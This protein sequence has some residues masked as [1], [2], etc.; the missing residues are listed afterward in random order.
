M[1][2]LIVICLIIFIVGYY[3]SKRAIFSPAV[4]SSLLW[5]GT[6]LLYLLLYRE[7]A[8][9]TLGH[10]FVMG[11]A[12]WIISFAVGSLLLQT[13]KL[14]PIYS[15]ECSGSVMN[16]FFALSLC[17][18]PLLI[19]HLMSALSSGLT[20]SWAYNLRLSAL[21]MNE[22]GEVY[23]PIYYYL[24]VATY[25]L[26]LMKADKKTWYQPVIMGLLLLLF[27]VVMM[28]KLNILIFFVI[29]LFLLHY[30]GILK[31]GQIV[32][33]GALMV[34]VMILLFAIRQDSDTSVLETI[35]DMVDIYALRSCAA[36]E[37]LLPASSAHWGE[38]VFRI[39]YAIKYKLGF[40]PIEP[41]ETMLPWISEPA[42]TNTYTC[43]YPFY[44][45]FGF[46]GIAIFGFLEG[47]VLGWL[48]RMHQKGSQYCTALYAYLFYC[49]VMQFDSE[50]MVTILSAHIKFAIMIW[51]PF[52]VSRYHLLDIRPLSRLK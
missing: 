35:I 46:A 44:K 40:S 9:P 26:S 34:G 11:A 31:I 10:K 23:T 14:K 2:S 30:K 17:C 12:L 8:L 43:M 25:I 5:G 51:L 37:T 1:I 32:V 38:N 27:A 7:C 19:E 16:F 39:V 21:G 20:S 47:A 49:V 50:L 3:F 29:T 15:A 45:D 6:V 4:V 42:E 13:T 33:G 48:F 24:W 28:A 36:F 22:Q 18:V 41:I 52:V